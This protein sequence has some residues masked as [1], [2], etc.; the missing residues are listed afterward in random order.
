MREIFRL[1]SM[2]EKIIFEAYFFTGPLQKGVMGLTVDRTNEEELDKAKDFYREVMAREKDKEQPVKLEVEVKL[3]RK[4]RTIK[5]MRLLHGIINR[6]A[7]KQGVKP[8]IIYAGVKDSYY[9]FYPTLPDGRVLRKETGD[10][11]TVEES[12]VV[13]GAVLDALECQ[14]D[15]KDIW[16]L[17]YDARGKMERDPLDGTYSSIEDYKAKH[18]VCEACGVWLGDDEGQMA[19]IVPQGNGGSDED[20]NR[21]RLCT[22]HHM[23][24]V[25]QNGLGQLRVKATHLKWKIDKS[26]ERHGRSLEAVTKFIISDKE[27]VDAKVA[28]PVAANTD[29]RDDKWAGN[30]EEQGEQLDIF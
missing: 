29:P 13:E 20:W 7:E 27:K 26:L 14:A 22:K 3:W 10:L 30:M 1:D 11:T 25:H 12:Q 21:L 8:A 24:C 4:R 9:P 19:H 5:Q 2:K 16:I 23:F 6:T 18:P 15:I 17:W 28:E